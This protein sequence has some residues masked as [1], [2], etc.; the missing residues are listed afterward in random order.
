MPD[1]R[2]TGPG[3]HTTPDGVLGKSDSPQ[4]YDVRCG[5]PACAIPPDPAE[6]TSATLADRLR[7]ATDVNRVY[8]SA[9]IGGTTAARLAA[10][11]AQVARLTRQNAALIRLLV[12]RDTLTD[13]IID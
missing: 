1:I 12:H 3:P 5:S 7:A 11:E 9:S 10:L 13:P 6:T 8:L 2:C 4:R